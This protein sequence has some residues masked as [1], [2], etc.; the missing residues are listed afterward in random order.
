MARTTLVPIVGSR[1]HC[2]HPGSQYQ[3]CLAHRSPFQVGERTW[4]YLKFEVMNLIVVADPAQSDQ[5]ADM[6]GRNMTI[7]QIFAQ[8]YTNVYH[9]HNNP[10]SPF[11]AVDGRQ[12]DP[13]SLVY[14]FSSKFRPFMAVMSNVV[15]QSGHRPDRPRVKRDISF[16]CEHFLVGFKDPFTIASRRKFE[17]HF[18]CLAFSPQKRQF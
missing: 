18:R 4:D 16:G 6:T 9:H 7:Y 14:Q 8:R 10:N 15:V 3:C 5:I 17:I 2:H 13:S 11:K 12:L 1:G